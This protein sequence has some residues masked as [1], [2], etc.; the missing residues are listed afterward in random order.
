MIMMTIIFFFWKRLVESET[1]KTIWVNSEISLAN[2]PPSGF[3]ESRQTLEGFQLSGS[4]NFSSGIAHAD[5]LIGVAMTRMKNGD[6]V[7]MMH[8]LP[9]SEARIEK[10]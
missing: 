5:W 4:W 8:L 10:S 9:K 2:G 1:A 6:H 3:C 7:S